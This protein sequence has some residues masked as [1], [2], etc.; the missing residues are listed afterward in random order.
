MRCRARAVAAALGG[1][2]VFSNDRDTVVRLD[3]IVSAPTTK[4]PATAQF[5]K[6]PRE[7]AALGVP[8]AP[9]P[10]AR[11]VTPE[12]GQ[13]LRINWSDERGLTHHREIVLRGSVLV[14]AGVPWIL[15]R[16]LRS[17]TADDPGEA[18]LIA[19]TRA[20]PPPPAR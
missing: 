12:P 9:S 20:S 1:T 8:F 13:I 14:D 4:P 5:Q 19:T 11:F 10:L 15:L 7:G 2:T 3:S 6:E 17:P 18:V 16:V